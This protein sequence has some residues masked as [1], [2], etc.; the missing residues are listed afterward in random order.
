MSSC[1][2]VGNVA[3]TRQ[4]VVQKAVPADLE[5]RHL[6]THRTETFRDPRG[7]QDA[8]VLGPTRELPRPPMQPVLNN[9]RTAATAGDPRPKRGLDASPPFIEPY[10]PTLLDLSL[11]TPRPWPHLLDLALAATAFIVQIALADSYYTL[12]TAICGG[13]EAALLALMITRYI[14]VRPHRLPWLE[15]IFGVYYVEFTVPLVSAPMPVGLA[16]V[17]PRSD[18]FEF[19]GLLALVSAGT[20]IAGFVL[21][22]RLAQ[23]F[24]GG[25]LLPDLRP[26]TLMAAS[27]VY[28]P[29]VGLYL[30]ITAYSPS[31]NA[32]TLSV[33]NIVCSIFSL[34]GIIS[35]PTIVYVTKPS[36]SNRLQLIAATV[37]IMIVMATSSMLGEAL[38][39]LSI[40]FI[41]WW[42]GRERVPMLLLVGLLSLFFVLQPVKSYYRALRWGSQPDVQNVVDA[43]VEAFNQASTSSHSSF[44]TRLTGSEA[45]VQRLNE[46]SSLAYVVE[47]VPASIPHSGG[48]IYPIM[49]TAAIPRVF[50]PEKPN[51]TSYALA[52]VIAAL[53]IDTME[54]TE[55]SMTGITLTAEGYFEHG[56]PGSLAWTALLGVTAAL[57]SR[58]FGTTLA[59]TVA[60]AH[61]MVPFAVNE[62]G[63]F[64]SL[65][66]SLW[67]SIAG[68]IA[69]VWLLWLVGGGYNA[70]RR[71][72]PGGQGTAAYPTG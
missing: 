56:V 54:G 52:S 49:L 32:A 65:F 42:R 44:N 6:R 39:P 46:L 15:G 27:R 1:S 34:T 4:R 45:T 58:C 36:P 22:S 51:M 57:L 24:R 53:G 35:I 70:G 62:G 61:L 16:R 59:G 71:G 19:A 55:H 31:F 69:V 7:A 68:A 63:G 9:T 47:T 20:M 25:T 18:S 2:N 11:A 28:V 41:L 14:R 17:L 5:Q 40:F 12:P 38:V 3:Y 64:F 43:W 33:R 67:Q 30:M 50:W 66:G 48:V 72:E 29:V 37:T 13:V 21:A 60:S 10:R 26:D 23:R 8:T